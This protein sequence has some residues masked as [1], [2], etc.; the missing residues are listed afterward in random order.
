MKKIVLL[1]IAFT[2]INIMSPHEVKA[3]TGSFYEAEFLDNIYTRRS[4]NTTVYYQRSRF[5]RER[6][7]GKVA[8]CIEPF[9][10]FSTGLDFIPTDTFVN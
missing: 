6:G 10:G 5:F 4:L 8:Y 9:T 1:L 2:A 7:T 3:E